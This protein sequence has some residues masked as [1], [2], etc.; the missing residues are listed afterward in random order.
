MRRLKL[1]F[2]LLLWLPAIPFP[3]L[4]Q[5]AKASGTIKLISGKPSVYITFVKTGPRKPLYVEDG[6]EGIWLRIHN[7]TRR[8]I[9]IPAG[10]VS[11]EYGDLLPYYDIESTK[12]S[13]TDIPI[14]PKSVHIV[15]SASLASGRSMVFSIPKEHLAKDLRIRISI[16]FDWEDTDDVSAGREV[17][18]F[19]YF[20]SADLPK[21]VV[22]K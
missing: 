11:P 16:N 6:E 19:V 14:G 2:I 10:G 15:S 4:A 12:E 13:K 17:E 18:H 5:K 7:N 8:K 21:G 22:E 1:L 3:G 9:F 20:S